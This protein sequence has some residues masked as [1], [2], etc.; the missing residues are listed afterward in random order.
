MADDIQS[1]LNTMTKAQQR[2]DTE[3]TGISDELFYGV[4]KEGEWPISEII[5]RLVEIQ[6]FWISKLNL[7]L[8]EN[9]PKLD[10]TDG[11]RASWRSIPAAYKGYTRDIILRNLQ[12]ASADALED[13]S[14]LPANQLNRTGIRRDGEVVNIP[15]MVEIVADHVVEHANQIADNK[16]ALK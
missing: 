6:G 12:H 15:R 1:M 13:I 8:G 4:P 14:K 9:N 16:K 2:L 5:S 10:R 7:M 11:E 3:L